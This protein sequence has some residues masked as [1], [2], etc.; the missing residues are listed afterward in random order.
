M[1]VVEA[2]VKER[3]P[4]PLKEKEYIP[5]DDKNQI[6]TLEKSLAAQ[7]PEKE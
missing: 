2:V 6:E 7:R 3:V 1:P 5:Y 4:D